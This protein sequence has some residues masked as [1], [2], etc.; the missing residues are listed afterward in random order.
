MIKYN[1]KKSLK[2]NL[3]I[4][5]VLKSFF[6]LKHE[7]YHYTFILLIDFTRFT[8]KAVFYYLLKM[9]KIS[10]KYLQ[11]KLLWEIENYYLL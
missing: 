6:H 10:E 1:L 9:K 3:I 2:I 5:L 8:A 11:S 4:I 7:C